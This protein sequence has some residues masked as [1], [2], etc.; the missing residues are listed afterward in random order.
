MVRKSK[1]DH[2]LNKQSLMLKL[3]NDVT[4]NNHGSVPVQDRSQPQPSADDTEER[5]E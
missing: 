5:H 1:K 3:H 4:L 2:V